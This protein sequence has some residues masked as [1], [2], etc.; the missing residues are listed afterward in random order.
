MYAYV[1]E[2]ILTSTKTGE[3]LVARAVRDFVTVHW[4]RSD[5]VKA[6]LDAPAINEAPERV[7]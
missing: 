6:A 2:T 1:L 3:P 4:V 7:D 5:R